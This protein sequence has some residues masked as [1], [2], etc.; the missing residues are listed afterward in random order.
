MTGTKKQGRSMS[1]S[2]GQRATIN[3]KAKKLFDDLNSGKLKPPPE[4]QE[5]A[6]EK[7]DKN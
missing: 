7:P 2:V 6:Q 4:A 5:A 3:A 1:L